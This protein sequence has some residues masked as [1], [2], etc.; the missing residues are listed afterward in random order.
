MQT[1]NNQ[2]N[3][4]NNIQPPSNGFLTVF[5]RDGKLGTNNRVIEDTEGPRLAIMCQNDEKVSE[6][7]KRYRTKSNFY[8]DAKFIFNAK[9]LN[10]DLTVA[11]S[12]IQQNSNIFV[13]SLKGIKG[14]Y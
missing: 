2:A 13:I 9:S 6:I 12:G 3:S 10:P 14:A 4:M 11:E 8:E 1:N 5:F 7:I